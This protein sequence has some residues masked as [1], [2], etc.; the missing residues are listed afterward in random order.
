MR[1]PVR[2]EGTMVTTQIPNQTPT[3]RGISDRTAQW[4]KLHPRRPAS[5]NVAPDR[6]GWSGGL[7]SGPATSAS[8]RVSPPHEIRRFAPQRDPSFVV[9]KSFTLF[10]L[11]FGALLTLLFGC[12]LAVALP[13]YRASL[14]FDFASVVCGVMLLY[15]SWDV[16]R[17][18]R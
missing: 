13:L 15:L 3:V 4:A 2:K 10:G 12:D 6:R 9:Q 16:L 14:L 5:P 18:Q 11:A 17:D 7:A 1:S 8:I